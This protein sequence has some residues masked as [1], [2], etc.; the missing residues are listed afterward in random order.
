MPCLENINLCALNCNAVAALTSGCNQLNASGLQP[1][2]RLVPLLVTFATACRERQG[3]L[4]QR[5]SSCGTFFRGG[6]HPSEEQARN[7]QVH[8]I[9]AQRLGLPVVQVVKDAREHTPKWD[10]AWHQHWDTKHSPMFIGH[11]GTLA[12]ETVDCGVAQQRWDGRHD[13]AGEARRLLDVYKSRAN[14]APPLGQL[15]VCTDAGGLAGGQQVTHAR[16]VQGR[17]S[18][19]DAASLEQAPNSCDTMATGKQHWTRTPRSNMAFPLAACR[20]DKSMCSM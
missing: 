15:L 6:Q 8:A 14:P 2:L 7:L 4:P 18:G 17:P 16:E 19:V 10:T 5:V 13:A 12:I 9:A 20:Y 11:K 1:D 3:G